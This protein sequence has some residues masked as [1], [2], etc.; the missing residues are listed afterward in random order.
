[1]L[2]YRHS[3]HAGNHA[4]VIKHIVQLAILQYYN[5]KDK[6][7]W[8]ID[9][10]AGAGMYSLD[11][12]HAQLKGEYMNG[13]AKLVGRDD[14]P[15]LVAEYVAVV[16]GVNNETLDW[17]PGS[18]AI[19]KALIRPEDKQ[20]LFELHPTDF[21][22]LREHF[23]GQR[24]VQMKQEDGFAGL[25]SVLPPPPRRAVVLIDPPYELKEDYGHVVRSLNEAL[26]RF[27]QGTYMVW[28]PIVRRPEWRRMLEKL[29]KFD[30]K[31]LSVNLTV[32]QA[33]EDGFGM[34][35][36]GIF[37]INPP[38]VLE[39]QMKEVLPFLVKALGQFSGA[40]FNI[41]SF[42]PKRT[43]PLKPANEDDLD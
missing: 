4:D 24:A 6:P 14:L 15:D 21:S 1:M 40:S 39:A 36:S 18:P 8:V 3:F 33:D 11:S 34:Q 27:A 28:Y 26:L 10:H 38:W 5:E 13:I 25:K 22:L 42:E 9:T 12:K 43:K 30:V 32:A 16:Q 7:Y 41:T 31:W 37:V 2:A 20:R 23:S 19:S 17:Y 29:E 35:G